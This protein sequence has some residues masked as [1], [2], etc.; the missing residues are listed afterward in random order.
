MKLA[1]ILTKPPYGD[2]QAAEALR[3]SLGAVGDE[4]D[5]TMVLVDGGVLLSRK[6]QSQGETGYTNLGET[7]KDVVDMGGE[8]FADKTSLKE[9][10]LDVDDLIEGVQVVNGYDISERVRDADKTMIF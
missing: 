10:G 5:L 6:G 7:L 3:H 9:C 2:V 1:V 8:V 4:I